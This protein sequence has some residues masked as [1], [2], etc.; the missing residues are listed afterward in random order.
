MGEHPAFDV[1]ADGE[2]PVSVEAPGRR[3]PVAA[4]TGRFEP[5]DGMPDHP[6]VVVV[7]AT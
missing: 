2:V 7:E 5:A 3:H 6:V 1:V 4:Q